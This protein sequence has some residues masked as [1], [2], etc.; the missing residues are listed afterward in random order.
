MSTENKEKET[1]VDE[2]KSPTPNH[3]TVEAAKQILTD[4]LEKA[5]DAIKETSTPATSNYAEKKE[6]KATDFRF[7]FSL[8][9][10]AVEEIIADYV[11]EC[12]CDGKQVLLG[13]GCTYVASP[14]AAK[15]FKTL[16]E[17]QKFIEDKHEK[18][19]M[20]EEPKILAREIKCKLNELGYG[21]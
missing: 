15:G 1:V 11:I 3:E 13:D 17:A 20:L 18:L 12:R 9:K 2:V 5:V 19:L 6:K 4:V 16:S 14:T 10:F 8:G 7:G 21:E